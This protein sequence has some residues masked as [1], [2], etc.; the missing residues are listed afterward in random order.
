[1]LTCYRTKTL[2]LIPVLNLLIQP[3]RVQSWLRAPLIST[4]A[5]LPLRAQ[6]V[7]HT[8]EFVLSVHPSSTG[9]SE[10]V[11][12]GRG[13][14]ITHEA[15]NAASRL[16]SSPPVGMPPQDWF[17]G[18][19]PQLLSLL[20]GDGEP[21]MDR[22]AAFIIGFGIL[23]RKQFGAPGMPGWNAFVNPI[24]VNI[25]PTLTA[26]HGSHS[27]HEK[28][29]I[30][31][32]GI[33][34]ILSTSENVSQ[35][36]KRLLVLLTSHPHPSLTK[37]L[38]SPILLPL[39][40]ISSWPYRNDSLENMYQKP[41]RTLLKTL[42]QLLPSIKPISDNGGQV[43]NPLFTILQN[44]T[45]SGRP[46]LD[47]TSWAYHAAA[48]G[49]IH[50]QEIT[51]CKPQAIDL[52]KLDVAVEN[53]IGLLQDLPDMDSDISNL[54]MELCTRWLALN[55]KSPPS[56]LIYHNQNEESY[57]VQSR[58]VEAKVMQ[59]MMKELP[60]KLVN[61]SSQ[62]L[63]LVDRVLAEFVATKEGDEDMV[64]IGLSLLNIVLISPS[65]R[66]SDDIE[67]QWKSIKNAL[68]EI[69]QMRQKEV[70]STSS[71][72]LLILGFHENMDE[73]NN[74]STSTATASQIEDRKTYG[75]AMS[76]LTATDSPPPIRAQGLQ[77]ISGLVNSDS[78]VLD[79]PAILVLLSS[80]LQDTEEY[81][82]LR[83][84]RL[85][86]QLSQRH[87]RAVMKDLIDRYIDPN[88]DCELD[89]RLRLGEALLQV[90]QAN[91]RVFGGDLARSVCE[92]LVFIA[93][94]RSYRP[95]TEQAQE[96]KNKLKRKQETE[97]EEAWGGPVPQLDEV[98][99]SESPNDHELISQ[100]V[101]GWESKRG[102]EDIR[103]RASAISILGSGIEAN[104]SGV[105]SRIISAAVDLGIHILTL[106][107]EAEKG[108]L[109]RASILLI[110]SFIK[111]LSEA[112]KTGRKLPFGFVGQ[113]LDDVQRVLE[114]VGQTDNDRLV[115]EHA[116]DVA[117][118]LVHWQMESLLPIVEGQEFDTRLPELA[119]LSIKPS[120]QLGIGGVGDGR[121]RIEEI[122]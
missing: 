25:D 1:M 40:S 6:G 37:R 73:P 100:I 36:L 96:N 46:F 2:A 63:N 76:Y 55:A 24:L 70:S 69:S 13:S 98:L 61:D 78:P 8:I 9:K 53:F 31:T 32:L 16:I 50:I 68:Q 88:E 12:P 89:Q 26:P 62:V 77:L 79:I 60:N 113:S 4:L 106:E 109:R 30:A 44:L 82:Y 85:L 81:I 20:D 71:N 65:F 39:W 48:G 27:H 107:T 94:R 19:S 59:K 3:G 114:Y 119:G 64:S 21:E 58:L 118:S 83:A 80:L 121:P 17:N 67:S 117:E 84:I 5:R 72:L 112:R 75:L 105:G 91:H 49:G 38:L 54:F 99:G 104:I 7:Q 86:V 95:K 74:L 18:I 66:K 28:G 14:N 90:I 93:S 10:S 29:T 33:A 97:A 47:Q 34:K 22:A 101:S 11:G 23:G 111:A 92:G 57:D 42:I 102:T 110:M 56:I 35:S 103:I 45:F 122:E 115:C 41:A 43:P 87:P 52:T 108:I 120:R 116:R 51:G 15:L